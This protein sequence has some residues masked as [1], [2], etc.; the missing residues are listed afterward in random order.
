[1]A[2]TD[3][4]EGTEWGGTL[5]DD[6]QLGKGRRGAMMAKVGAELQG[7]VGTGKTC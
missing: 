5:G 6:V 3:D 7:G 4:V 1:M 2:P